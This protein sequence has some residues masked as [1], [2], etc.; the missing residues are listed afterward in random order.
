MMK[1]PLMTKVKDVFDTLWLFIL[2]SV[3]VSGVVYLGFKALEYQIAKDII[4]VQYELK[5]AKDSAR[6]AR[7]TDTIAAMRQRLKV[8]EGSVDKYKKIIN[9][10]YER[11]TGRDGKE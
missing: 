9:K 11:R 1:I 6:I 2:V 5:W 3:I 7:Q 4:A 10:K 8:C